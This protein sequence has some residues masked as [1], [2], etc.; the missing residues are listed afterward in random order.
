MHIH[1]L[2]IGGT[3]M[4]GIAQ[5]A[6]SMGHK[7]TGCDNGLY[8][9]MS[10]VLANA[11][12]DY[13][14]G[15]SASPAFKNADIIVVGNIM[16]RGD[17]IVEELLNSG[18]KYMSGPQWLEEFVLPSRWVL[19][20]SGTHGKTTTTGLL[21]FILDQAG[22]NPG[23]LI[24]GQPT[25]F[26]VTARV[27]DSPFFVIEADEYDT[28]FFDKRSKFIHYHPNTLV[29]NNLEFDHAD[30]F[31]N[32][33][34]IQAQFHQLI[35]TVPGNGLII[36]PEIETNIQQVLSM[37]CWTPVDTFLLSS[38]DSP[39]NTDSW[40]IHLMNETGEQFAMY[41]GSQK[42]AEVCWKLSGRHNVMNATSALLA[43]R[44]A[45]VPV[46]VIVEAI[47]NFEG[48]KKRMQFIGKINDIEV[49]DDFAHHPSA[50]KATLEAFRSKHPNNRLIV[51]FEPRSN[52]MKMGRH[53]SQLAN[54]LSEADQVYC[55]LPKKL[56]WSVSEALNDSGFQWHIS[57]N[58]TSLAHE[59]KTVARPGDR[60]L[61][62]SNGNFGGM[63][64]QLLDMFSLEN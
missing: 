57:D 25:N 47:E 60:I 63:P 62:M 56:K 55:W 52:T 6:K 61:F 41:K 17:A 33:S 48:I 19:A 50:I 53:S 30:I 43:A 31:T 37:G 14:M 11:G 54:A 49:Y 15:F 1:I 35:R 10:N 42:M 18:R 64:D 27:T 7:V 26:N 8:P 5:I 23:F 58:L 24:G 59:L 34:E 29:I 44:H 2:G 51:V 9:P 36:Y 46:N 22:L 40:Q 16:K 20:V 45:G 13:E 32:L 21:A 39:A 12:I 28:A 4:A 38:S 3:F